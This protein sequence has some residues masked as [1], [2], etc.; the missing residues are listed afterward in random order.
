MLPSLRNVQRNRGKILSI[1]Q[2]NYVLVKYTT[3]IQSKINLSI[4]TTIKEPNWATAV[5]VLFKL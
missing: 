1:E 2:L 5:E 3:A 4:F